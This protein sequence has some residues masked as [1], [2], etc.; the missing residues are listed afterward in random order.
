[1]SHIFLVCALAVWVYMTLAFVLALILKD[2]SIV[3]ILWGPGFVLVASVSLA[4]GPHV[5]RRPWLVTALVVLWGFRLATHILV[6]KLGKGEDFRYAHWRRAW[7]RSFVLR[8]YIQ[9]F[10]LQ[11]IFLL[12]IASPVILIA[13]SSGPRLGVWDG[14]GGLVWVAGFVF[15]VA[16]DAQMERFKREPAN[17]GRIIGTGLWR[18]SRHPNY[19]GEAAMWWG[20][21]LIGLAVPRGWMGLLSPV[22]ITVLLTK[23]SGV[24]LLEK[25]YAGN[26]EF[27]AYARRTSGFI[28]WFPKRDPGANPRGISDQ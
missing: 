10:I 1:M 22:L 14:L 2:N 25:K 6:R 24:P 26:A 4:L 28:P 12:I 9:I 27:A 8:S 3:D 21:F 20:I 5:G 17:K 7:G 16:S 11:G 15:E 18:Y 13:A 19:F 23:V